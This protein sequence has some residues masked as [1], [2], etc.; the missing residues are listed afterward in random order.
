VEILGKLIL[1]IPLIMLLAYIADAVHESR[2]F[3]LAICVLM[4]VEFILIGA[5]VWCM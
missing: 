2:V 4:A 5:Y 3:Y 1:T